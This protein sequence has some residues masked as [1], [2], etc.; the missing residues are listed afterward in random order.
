MQQALT[1]YV[2]DVKRRAFSYEYVFSAIKL[3]INFTI[4]EV[5]VN[6][7]TAFVRST[8]KGTATVNANGQTGP[9]KKPQAVRILEGGRP[10]ENCL[11]HVQ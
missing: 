11:L 2:S 5:V 3:D 10:V 8:S 4:D 6:G 9:K 7:N 1:H